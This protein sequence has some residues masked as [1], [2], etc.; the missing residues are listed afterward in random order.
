MCKF[1]DDLSWKTYIVPQRNTSA[2]DNQCL[3]GSPLI[4]DGEVFDNTCDNCDGCK[5]DNRHFGL[6]L[7]E[8]NLKLDYVSRIKK[9]II[10]PSSESI[11]INFCPWCGK[12]LTDNP[13]DF[14]KCCL[15][16]SLNVEN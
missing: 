12:S 15:G 10:E 11:R 2:D 7:W 16:R 5:K 13:V 4:L 9:L 3:F 1:C 14:D 8:N 6:T